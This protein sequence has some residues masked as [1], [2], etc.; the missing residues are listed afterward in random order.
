VN[1][2]I[3]GKATNALSVIPD[4]L[5]DGK[6]ADWVAL[7]FFVREVEFV[8]KPAIGDQRT[9]ARVLCASR[10]PSVAAL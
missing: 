4:T 8:A 7:M 5:V 1:W 3:K 2:R 9:A 6:V 10:G